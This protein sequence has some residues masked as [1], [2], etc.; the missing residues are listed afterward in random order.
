MAMGDRRRAFGQIIPPAFVLTLM[1]GL[2]RDTPAAPPTATEIA[3]AHRLA[4]AREQR[5]TAETAALGATG[6]GAAGASAAKAPAAGAA[7]AAT[8]TGGG[9][10]TAD[11]AQESQSDTTQLVPATAGNDSGSATATA[12]LTH[13]CC[14]VCRGFFAQPFTL[15]CR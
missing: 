7:V 9:G 15:S 5:E 3:T 6:A 8:A 12:A 10:Q 14:S 4:I 2:P 13:C 11:S 1:T